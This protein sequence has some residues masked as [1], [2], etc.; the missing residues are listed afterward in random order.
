MSSLSQTPEPPYLPFRGVK[1][2][3][4]AFLPLNSGL[5][6]IRCVILLPGYGDDPIECELVYTNIDE[7]S[8]DR[9]PYVALSY[10]WG[11]VEDTVEIQLYSPSTNPSS[12]S[13]E[14]ISTPF[15]IT[16]NLYIALQALRNEKRQCLWIDALCIN[17]QDPREK[18]HQV[19]LMGKIYSS[20]ESVVVWLGPEDEY[21]R[22]FM[23]AWTKHIRPLIDHDTVE[24]TWGLWGT[25]R[26]DTHPLWTCMAQDKV[27]SQL[28]S[29][30]DDE[31]LDNSSP[32]RCRNAMLAG[33]RSLV[34]RPWWS[35]IWVLQEV[36]L[37]PKNE[38][39]RQK[40]EF[41]IGSGTL[42][43][44]EISNTQIT[45]ARCLK[46]ASYEKIQRAWAYII[47]RDALPEYME[48]KWLLRFTRRFHASDPRDKLFALLLLASDTKDCL[49][50]EPLISPDYTKS[51]KTVFDDL[52]RWKPSLAGLKIDVEG[53]G[54]VK[55]T[56]DS[57]W[58]TM[59]NEY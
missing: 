10:C 50:K 23:R 53:I 3:D 19:Q 27:L 43:W 25:L 8:D 20:A 58:P 59:E 5:R 39:S 35:R 12:A 48:V 26:E 40:V 30:L 14:P 9:T 7:K 1:N 46:L 57:E 55:L 36:L 18:T 28:G 17:Q 52:I 21:I 11:A 44:Y 13:K 15:R 33:L 37:A 29:E 41:R 32:D 2:D 51:T 16:Q 42:R 34:S 6:E 56:G 31:M 47:A 45:S 4:T 38:E 49:W 22:F 24:Q 54:D